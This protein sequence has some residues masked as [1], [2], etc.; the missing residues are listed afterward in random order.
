MAVS[1][2]YFH[3]CDNYKPYQTLKTLGS[4]TDF[5]DRT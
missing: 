5:E 3:L 2:L 1:F 4:R